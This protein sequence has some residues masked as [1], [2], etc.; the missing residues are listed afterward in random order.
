M[1]SLLR[2]IELDWLTVK[3]GD[4][5]S[6]SPITAGYTNQCYWVKS[7]AHNQKSSQANW[8][9]KRFNPD[10]LTTSELKA[11]SQVRQW[12]ENN[13]LSLI[14][15][16]S[17]AHLGL[18]VQAY[19]PKGDLHSDIRPVSQKIIILAAQ[20]ALIHQTPINNS[21]S[22][23]LVSDVTSQN[24]YQ[25]VMALIA[26]N[27]LSKNDLTHLLEQTSIADN[28]SNRNCICH[29]DL[30]FQ[31]ILNTQPHTVTDW[32]YARLAEVE[33]DLASAI[34][35]NQLTD[36]QANELIAH[37]QDLNSC[38][39]SRDKIRRYRDIFTQINALWFQAS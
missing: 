10:R 5:I 31:N 17:N 9:I 2:D 27:R 35:I 30:S 6:V 4:I 28:Q 33:Y 15:Q 13:A 38:G 25:D 29:G 39:L 34:V 36:M 19:C 21:L 12:A 11:E 22:A 23:S 32:E 24:L 14:T 16:Y 3:L 20:L 8:F 26:K 7:K 18:L 1:T 37:Y